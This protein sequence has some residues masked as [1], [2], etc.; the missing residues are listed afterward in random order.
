MKKVLIKQLVIVTALLAVFSAC[1]EENYES[2]VASPYIANLDLRK[3]YKGSEVTLTQKNM[4][5]AQY[6]K[7]QVI[8][9]HTGGNLPAGIIFVQNARKISDAVDSLRGIA[10]NVGAAASSYVPGDSIHVK[11]EGGT[12]KRVDGLLQITGVSESAVE[13]KASGVKLRMA[14]MSAV[15]LKLNPETFE[16]CLSVVYNC[17][18]EP[19]IGVETIEGVK[20]FNEGSGDLQMNVGSTATFKSTLLPWSAEITG[21]V[22]PSAAN[23]YQIRPRIQS[24]FKATSIIVDPSIPLGTHPAIITGYFANP[25]GSDADYEYIQLMATQDLDFRQH[26]FAVITTNNAGASTPLGAPTAGWATGGMRTYKFNITK[27]T[28]AKG[29]YFYVG[30]YKQIAGSTSTDIS[31]S[32]W[33]VSKLYNTANTTGDDGVGNPTANLLANS[34]N[35]AGIAVF[36]TTAVDLRTI[37]SDVIMFGGSGGTVYEAASGSKPAYGYAICDNDQYSTASNRPFYRMSSSI[38]A[39][40]FVLPTDGEFSYFKGT[41]DATTKTWTTKRTYGSKAIAKSAKLVEIEEIEDA[42]K[43]VN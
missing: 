29:T 33:V 39:N 26:N 2:G 1:K 25:S 40:R 9:D 30:G 16:S 19:N 20:N 12:L 41:Y 6:L 42:V 5:G 23:T 8:S 24:D 43:V 37:P 27:G 28:V 34:G 31:Q 10:I 22:I 38:N 32:N 21:I 3:I 4:K 18:F 13:K 15:T 35:V 14:K 11:I 7:G 17:N 36:K